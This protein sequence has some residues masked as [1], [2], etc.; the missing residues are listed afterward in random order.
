[1]SRAVISLG[2]NIDPQRHLPAAAARLAELGRVVAA[3]RVYAS[4]AAGPP[5]QPDFLN[6]AVLLE[7]EIAP[8]DLRA[9]LRR[10]ET[11]LGRV[12]TEDR[13]A[14]RPIDLDLVL[15]DDLVV[16]GPGLRLP[17]PDLPTRGYLAVTAAEVDPERRH[18]VTG[19][20][21]AT[22]ATRLVSAARL[23]ARPDIILI[24]APNEKRR[25]R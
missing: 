9:R 3:S 11:D 1:M 21:L 18:P 22:M 2:S 6:A 16:E 13:Y 10:V 8:E 15:Y 4:P 17:D 25:G 20:T 7:T 24:P 12:R 19:E 5:G 23:T 14:P